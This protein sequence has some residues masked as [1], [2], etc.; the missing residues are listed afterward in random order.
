MSARMNQPDFL[1]NSYENLSE[2][3]SSEADDD[4]L[5]EGIEPLPGMLDFET[6]ADARINVFASLD[7]KMT[8]HIMEAVS[9][10]SELR[11]RSEEDARRV[12]MQLE[13]QRLLLHNEVNTLKQERTRLQAELRLARREV[14]EE[15]ARK[16]AL[17]KEASLMHGSVESSP[18]LAREVI[19]LTRRV[20]ELS[21]Q[22]QAF[23]QGKTVPAVANRQSYNPVPSTLSLEL[24]FESETIPN[25]LDKMM[26]LPL[27]EFS[28]APTPQLKPHGR[29]KRLPLEESSLPLTLTETPEPQAEVP[30][31][32]ITSKIPAQ[33]PFELPL[34]ETQEKVPSKQ[35]RAVDQRLHHLLGRGFSQPRIEASADA[36]EMPVK[37][38]S[39]NKNI[40]VMETRA[41]SDKAALADLGSKLGVQEVQTPP[42]VNSIKLG[43]GFNS[44]SYTSGSNLR[45]ASDSASSS[46][47]K[48]SSESISPTIVNPRQGETVMDLTVESERPVIPAH[49][50]P[51]TNP[52][53]ETIVPPARLR[54]PPG[55]T[56]G[57][58]NFNPTDIETKLIISNLQGLSLL[59]MEK[60]IRS[61]PGVHQVTVTDFRKG[62]LVMDVRHH[63][64]LALD[65]VLPQLPDLNLK[66]ISRD[67]GLMFV[68]ER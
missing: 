68:Q 63:L 55:A 65:R 8:Q 19:A 12:A 56:T 60:V 16:Y 20:Q 59:V 37:V 54:P 32:T 53:A 52:A 39:S 18:G 10:L 29:I 6:W 42:P 47:I 26:H 15:R 40:E 46:E 31:P 38:V 25:E 9:A 36:G 27:Q 61:L 13:Q 11:V 30:I 22:L 3:F 50:L 57:N 23:I 51:R 35:S 5:D 64:S 66:L 67:D 48:R 62:E 4:L 49:L 34:V 58:E 45:D 2:P 44:S 7:A 41:K 33:I 21:E 24:N 17:E 14:E 28:D 1:G 43:P